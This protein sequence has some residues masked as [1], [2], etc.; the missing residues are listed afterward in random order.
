MKFKIDSNMKFY[1]VLIMIAA[2]LMLSYPYVSSHGL[3]AS[4]KTTTS[5]C[6]DT[7]GGINYNIKGIISTQNGT[8]FTDYCT[9]ATGLA[10]WYCYGGTF[11]VR[12]LYTCSYGCSSGTCASC[13]ATNARCVASYQCCSRNCCPSGFCASSGGSCAT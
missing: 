11:P 6:Y 9:S 8:S 2:V 10:E 7:D 12:S 3:F 5:T 13:R 1:I 4:G